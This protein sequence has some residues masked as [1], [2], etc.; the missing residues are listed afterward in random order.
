MDKVYVLR[1]KTE[2][3]TILHTVGVATCETDAI[4]WAGARPDGVVER[5]YEAMPII[6]TEMSSSLSS[7]VVASYVG[8]V[9]DDG[10]VAKA[11]IEMHH[12]A[13]YLGEHKNRLSAARMRRLADE[14]ADAV[15]LEISE[16]T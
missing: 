9:D 1:E 4:H 14:A 6:D 15:G 7:A 2:D 13:D 12:A 3:D 8:D 11:L 10:P 16:T 5:G